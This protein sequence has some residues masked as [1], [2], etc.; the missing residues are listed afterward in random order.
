MY[1][2]YGHPRYFKFTGKCQQY[3]PS[4]QTIFPFLMTM[5]I[6]SWFISYMSLNLNII[7]SSSTMQ[8][9][10]LSNI[11]EGPFC[12]KSSIINIWQGFK[13]LSAVDLFLSIEHFNVGSTLFQ[14][15]GST[16]DSH[17]WYNVSARCWCYFDNIDI[18][19]YEAVQRRFIPLTINVHYHIETSQLICIANYMTGFYIMENIGC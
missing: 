4:F 19:F 6:S 7:R 12:V 3:G 11:Y 1:A 18:K 17:C 2:L 5:L 9:S 10:T 14:C 16:S 8:S 13:H 15:C